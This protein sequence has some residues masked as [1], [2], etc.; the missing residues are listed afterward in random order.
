MLSRSKELFEPID[1]GAPEFAMTRN[2]VGGEPYAIR[3]QVKSMLPTR[4][5][6]RDEPGSLEDRKVLGDLSG[7][8]GE[9]SRES[10]YRLITPIAEP[11]EQAAACRV[12]Q[13][14]ED[15]I[16]LRFARAWP[17]P[18]ARVLCTR[19]VPFF[20]VHHMVYC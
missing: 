20:Y 15:F 6:P 9:R 11:R 3:L 4:D 18:L 10:S 19:A 2:P 13:R 16:E 17:S 1:A 12:T 7:R 14:E 8:L 5:P